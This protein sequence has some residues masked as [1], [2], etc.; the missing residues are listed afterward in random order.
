MYY[1]IAI[2]VGVYIGCNPLCNSGMLKFILMA[3]TEG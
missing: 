3:L 2:A 1:L